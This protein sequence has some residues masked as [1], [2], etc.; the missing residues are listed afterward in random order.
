[1]EYENLLVR[2][3]G[4]VGVIIINRPDV[5]NA[6][7]GATM[8]AIEQALGD[9]DEDDAVRC[10]VMTGAGDKAFSAGGDIHEMKAGGGEGRTLGPLT[11]RAANLRKPLIG[12]LNGLAFGAGA[13]LSSCMDVRIGCERSRFRFVQA[14]IGRIGA[15]WT[16]PL[17]VGLP[18]ARELLYS[19]RVVEAEEALRIGLLNR[20]VPAGEVLDSALELGRQIAANPPDAVQGIKHLLDDHPGRTRP[21]MLEAETSIRTDATRP[22][23]LKDAFKDF[24]ARAKVAR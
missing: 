19:A 11:V 18:I 9:M 21:E 15:T 5:L 10:I 6:L 3:D 1:M 24:P 8:R 22:K 7:N 16:L 4:G 20:L 17:I 12:A 2:S 23:P 13:L 14:S